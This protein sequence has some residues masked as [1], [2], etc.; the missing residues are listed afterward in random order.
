MSDAVYSVDT[1]ALIDGLERYYPEAA[2]PALWQRVDGLVDAGQFVIS[3]E[4]W[5]EVQKRDAV[6]K[7]WCEPRRPRLLVPTDG[8]ITRH[9]QQVLADHPRLVAQMKGRNRADPF[10]IAVARYRGCVVLTGE[11][12]DGTAN[13]PKIPYVCQQ[14]GIRVIRFTELII[15]EGWVFS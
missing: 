14:L 12:S 6:A 13:R 5:E 11:G 9:V 15:E 7:A 8:E 1:S 3:D 2:F 4:V 10:V